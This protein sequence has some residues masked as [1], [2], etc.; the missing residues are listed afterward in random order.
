ME[1]ESIQENPVQTNNFDNRLDSN[2]NSS[3]NDSIN[4]FVNNEDYVERDDIID[5]CDKNIV[6]LYNSYYKFIM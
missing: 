4:D 1:E 6:Y 2:S 5:K 3:D